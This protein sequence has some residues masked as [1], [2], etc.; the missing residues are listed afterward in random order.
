MAR[1]I[2]SDRKIFFNTR[3]RLT[4]LYVAVLGVIVIGFSGLL[5]FDFR[6]DLEGVSLTPSNTI[7]NEEH[8]FFS[9]G[10]FQGLVGQ[11]LIDDSL[12]LI[13]AS[14]LSYLLAGYT[15]RPIHKT[16]AAQKS[17]VENAS[18]ELRTP[19]AVIKSAAEVLQRDPSPSTQATQK[20]LAS[21]VEEVD[22]MTEMSQE[23]LF[24]A[25]SGQASST[26]VSDINLAKP[27]TR[28]VKTLHDFAVERKVSL[29]L[30]TKTLPNIVGNQA[31][32]ERMFF[33]LIHNAIEH[34][35]K[36][37]EVKITLSEEAHQ[38]RVVILDTG[39]GIEADLLPHVFERFYKGVK[40]KGSGLGLAIVKDIVVRH[41]G[42]IQIESIVGEGTSVSLSFPVIL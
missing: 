23:L 27:A 8:P 22:R 19:L 36:G 28:V 38:A 33:N 31:E 2:D 34:T 5:L 15:L 24:L 6:E 3:I 29:I 18:H 11:M 39:E 42:D 41:K 35:P 1:D 9:K 12:I 10:T 20:T 37:G 26:Q 21:I 40:S 32:L 17:F 16:L 4:C 30:D 25:R 13:V 14:F 7:S